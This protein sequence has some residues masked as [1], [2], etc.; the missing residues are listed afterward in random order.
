MDNHVADIIKNRPNTLCKYCKRKFNNNPLA[1][2]HEIDCK[3]SKG[4]C[5][6][7]DEFGH[8]PIECDHRKTRFCNSCG[9]SGHLSDVCFMVTDVN[10]CIL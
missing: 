3:W 6:K 7:C 10:M 8:L 1:F 4:F 5:F 9:R 2:Y